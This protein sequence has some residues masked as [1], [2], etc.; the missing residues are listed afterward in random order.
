MKH[1]K[2]RKNIKINTK[3]NKKTKINKKTNKNNNKKTKKIIIIKNK[4]P[5]LIQKI[6]EKVSDTDYND[7]F[8]PHLFN[9][10]NN[11]T[12]YSP[13]INKEIVT[14][15]TMPRQKILDCNNTLAFELKEPL[16]I[17]IPGTLYGKNC[18]DYN[19]PE[20]KKYLLKNLA[21]NKHVIISK[22]VPP[23]QLQANCWFNAMFTTFFISD[24]GR[25]FFHY[26]RELMIKG[27][28]KNGQIIQSEKLRNAFALLNFG[29][30]AC[31]TG[32]KYAYELNTNSIIHQIYE[33]IPKEYH[34]KYS[35]IVDVKKAS[36]PLMYYMSIINYL[37]NNSILILLVKNCNSNWKEQ[38]A[39]MVSQS[40]LPHI[41]VFEVFDGINKNAGDSGTFLNKP[42]SFDLK[43]GKYSLDSAV[44]RDT[45]GQH[46]CSTITCEH[47]EMGYDG[48]SFHR[49]VP[50]K[51]KD[52]INSNFTWEFE[53]SED[54]DK[55]PL[56]WSFTHG[57]QLLMYYRV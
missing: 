54:Y 9:K 50:L 53:G 10:K 29:I 36:N 25:K 32:N 22:I 34:S 20:A 46:F 27:K 21:A 38:I 26:F 28:Q 12:S 47:E 3:T 49:I 19:T 7:F 44:I 4:T 24:K 51:W 40:K 14:L 56:K 37:N 42:L 16:K 15:K 31:L 6:S 55:T 48:M 35:Y 57:Y 23:I 11:K 33:S 18:F 1:K 43:D 52:K 45:T 8:I 13:T 39:Q 5:L 17:G 30:E 2:S 41:I